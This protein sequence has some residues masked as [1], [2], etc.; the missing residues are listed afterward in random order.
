MPYFIYQIDRTQD[1][2]A[3]TYLKTFD[4]F[5]DAKAYARLHRAEMTPEAADQ[6]IK[7]IFTTDAHEAETLLTEHREAPILKE[8]EK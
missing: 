4:K 6:Q 5:R 8:W 2:P 3:L 1:T 7:I